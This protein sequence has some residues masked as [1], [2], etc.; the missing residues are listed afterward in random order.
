MTR[1]I[2]L[3]IALLMAAACAR[4]SGPGGLLAINTNTGETRSFGSAADVP[5]G[6]AECVDGECPAPR[7]CDAIDE[8]A[9]LVRAD[10]MPVYVEASPPACDG[11]TPPDF[12]SELPF[13]GCV[14]HGL[15]EP[16]DCGERPLAPGYVCD[17]GSMGG[18]T[19]RC[20]AMPGGV[21]GW[22]VRDCTPAECAAEDCGPPP[23]APTLLCPDGSAGGSTGRCIAH[24]DGGCGWEFRDC[25]APT[26]TPDDCGPRPLAPGYY[27]EDGSLGGFTGVCMATPD[28]C[29]WEVR[30]CPPAT[31]TVDLCAPLPAV[32]PPCP[33]GSAPERYC[34]ASAG[35]A[36]AWQLRCDA[37]TPDMC[38]PA[39]AAEFVCPGGT[40]AEVVCDR[41]AGACGWR[42][43]CAVT[44]SP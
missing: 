33:D 35:G 34:G 26:C 25:P 12:C 17:D 14:A 41:S 38:G 23:D 39:P 1:L 11:P 29:G 44:G 9:C 15:C 22:E 36:C 6:W 18:S 4:S 8:P 42:F 43:V 20:I 2:T 40:S 16:A 37:C 30:E 5:D 7:A 21:C 24:A 13:A 27:C 10:C 28:G 31:C 3:S 19:G 32:V